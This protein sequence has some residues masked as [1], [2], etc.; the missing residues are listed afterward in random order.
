VKSGL[1]RVAADTGIPVSTYSWRQKVTT[2]LRRARV[3][4]RSDAD[5]LGHRR[6]HLRTT[7]SYGDWDPDYQREAAAALDAWFWHIRRMGRKLAASQAAN[8]RG[9]SRPGHGPTPSSQVTI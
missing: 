5:L 9:Y 7:A 1:Q 3:P 4:E 6:P 8:S 2:V